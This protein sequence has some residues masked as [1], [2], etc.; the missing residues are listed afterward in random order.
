MME[1]VGQKKIVVE[2]MGEEM[3]TMISTWI[4]QS[5]ALFWLEGRK[6]RYDGDGDKDKIRQLG[7][8]V[9][10]ERVTRWYNLGWV[11]KSSERNSWIRKAKEI[12]T[13]M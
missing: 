8:F 3:N 2:V 6:I 4:L 12:W 5:Q 7:E 10:W 1:A 13:G 11:N 9:L